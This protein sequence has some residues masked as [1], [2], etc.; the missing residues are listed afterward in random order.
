MLILLIFLTLLIL[1]LPIYLV[2]IGS[3]MIYLLVNPIVPTASVIQRF[4]SST[5][6][7]PLLA[8]PLF[9]LAGN[10]MNISG[11]SRRILNFCY[12]LTAGRRGGLA[13]VNVL[14][15]TLL[16]GMSGSA[17]GD[18]AMQAKILVPEMVRRGYSNE[19]S[20]MITAVSSLIAPMIPPGISL[21]LYGFVTNV[22][23]GK[24]FIAGVL[25]GILM[26]LGLLL[27]V[28]LISRR[29]NY[30]SEKIQLARGEYYKAF[31][32]SISALILP[33]FI[34]VGIRF[35]I[36]TPT[37]SASIACLYAFAIGVLNREIKIQNLYTAIVDSVKTT[38]II[39]LILAASAG[40]S[41]ILTVEQIPQNFAALLIENISNK[42][43]FMLIAFCMLTVIGMFVEGTASI[44]I[45]GP[46]FLP[47][48][49]TLGIDPVQFG[50]LMVF[51]VNLG[52]VTPPLGTVMFA[53]C[54]ITRVEINDFVEESLPFLLVL[55]LI[56][57]LLIFVPQI[58]TA[59]IF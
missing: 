30:G 1:G 37:E 19:F 31:I 21:I 2:L 12:I 25:P 51:T 52:G 56:A 26:M 47:I 23:I 32:N 20:S 38:S 14:L 15:S 55:F 35:G 50:I 53:T 44:I 49:R 4:I 45:L 22:S 28:D 10:L 9:I 3:S 16:S 34:I 27:M 7:F 43:I 42:Y 18:A 41:Y 39:L 8:I 13:K 59:L 58:T 33:V 17:I 57:L 5:Q 48:V 6:S 54:S 29:R 46:L 11:I 40:F 24:L 36:F